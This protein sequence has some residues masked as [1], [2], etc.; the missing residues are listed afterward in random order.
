MFLKLVT[1]FLMQPPKEAYLTGLM[2]PEHTHK[3]L[4]RERARADRTGAPLS[5]ATFHATDPDTDR[6][7]LT[8]LADLLKARLRITDEVGWLS[9]NQIGALLIATSAKGAWRVIDKIL[10]HFPPDVP[11]PNCMV[12]TYPTSRPGWHESLPEAAPPSHKP[13][14]QHETVPLDKLLVRPM[15]PWK[16]CLDVLGALTGLIL[17]SPVLLVVALLVKFTSHGPV[18]FRQVRSGRGGQPF[19][20][21][22]FRTMVPDAEARKAALLALNERDGPAFKIKRD[23]RITPLGRILRSASLDELP[24]LWNV[25]RGDMTLVGP[26]PLICSE[27]SACTGWQRRRFEVTPGLTCIWQVSERHG[28]PFSTWMRMDVQ[29]IQNLSIWTDLKLLLLTVPAILFGRGSH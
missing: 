29:Y 7:T 12:Y 10:A 26:R 14:E 2:T 25:L 5:L 19:V 4:E 9:D 17:L 24:Q 22:K 27:A 1:R 15:P 11:R 28:L 13:V 21:Y 3:T 20:L 8:C 16:R 23:P 18:L 6:Q